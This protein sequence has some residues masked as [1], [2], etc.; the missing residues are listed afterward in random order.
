MWRAWFYI[1]ASDRNG[2]LYCGSTN[3]LGRRMWEHKAHLR[4]GFTSRYDVT[5]L[6]HYEGFELLVQ[7]RARE[8]AVKKWR[9]AW[10]LALIEARNP[11]WRDL[12]DELNN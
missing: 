2:T 1:L 11:S 7:A 9:R 8:Y 12:I 5:R 4:V 6:V 10:K 3:D